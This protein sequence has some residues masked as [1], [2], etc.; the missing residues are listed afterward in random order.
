M[1]FLHISLHTTQVFMRT[2]N[3]IF[4]IFDSHIKLKHCCNKQH[5]DVAAYKRTNYI[6]ECNNYLNTTEVD[7]HK[8]LQ[9][10]CP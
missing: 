7:V 1:V 9:S 10:L 3:N 4:T 8:H 5:A 6:L 2:R